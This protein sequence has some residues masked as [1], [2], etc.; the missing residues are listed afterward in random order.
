MAAGGA[1]FD[2]RHDPDRTMVIRAGDYEV[3]DIGTRF[4]IVRTPDHLSVAVA[5]GQVR[6]APQEGQG[7]V[8]IAGKRVDIAAAGG[9]AVVRPATADSVASWRGGRLVY[10][11]SPLALVAVDLARY[12]G[13]S[14]TVDPSVAD[15]RMS[16]VLSIGDGSK[17]IDQVEALLPVR[18]DIEGSRIRLVRAR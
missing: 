14:V 1:Y 13:R 18:A 17:L 3:R 6:V 9:E 16:G 7:L 11:N 5:Q 10:D 4:D 8:L 12:S 15:L 2:I